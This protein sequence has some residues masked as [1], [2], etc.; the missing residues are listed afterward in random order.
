[1][2]S[3]PQIN[4]PSLWVDHLPRLA[5]EGHKYDRGH[6]LIR[7]G[8]PMTGAARLAAMAAAR[9]GA[10]MTTVAA[11]AVAFSV[12]AATLASLIV[13]PIDQADDLTALLENRK[14]SA[15][16]IGPGAGVGAVTRADTLAMLA[17]G[18]PAVLD[19]DA[20]TS[21]SDE[22]AALFAALGPHC[23]LTPHEGEFARLFTAKGRRAERVT[24]AARLSGAVIIL[25]GAKTLVAAPDG[26]LVINENAPPTL[27][28]AG[29]G[30]V[31]AGIIVSL[32]AQG[33]RPFH[34]AAAGVWMHGAAAAAFGPGL[35]ADDLPD[36]LPAVLRKIQG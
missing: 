33:M 9:A 25:K 5:A 22:P 36:M 31:L 1:M 14:F 13:H 19:A 27:A 35:I 26:A 10:G 12:Y 16:L 32:L 23:V 30:D 15:L 18:L 8:Y 3:T 2:S 24:A 21:F 17:T 11:P 6:V 20:L 7:G 29:S 28:T 4:D 34:A